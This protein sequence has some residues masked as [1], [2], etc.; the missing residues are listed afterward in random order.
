MSH[1]FTARPSA[2][3]LVLAAYLFAATVPLAWSS[4]AADADDM[5]MKGMS[6]TNMPTHN[7]PMKTAA[8]P[9]YQWSGCYVG[10]NGGGGAAASNFTTT[11]GPGGHLVPGDA[12][13]VANDGTGSANTTNF[14]GGGQAGCNWQSGTIVAGL[15]GDFDFFH[16]A[17]SFFNNTNGLPSTGNPFVIGHSLTT[18][19]LATVRPRIGIAAGRNLAYVAGGVAFTK[20]NYSES[21]ADTQAPPGTGVATGS[22]FLTGWTAGAGWEYAWTDRWTIRFEYL[23]AAFPKTSAAGAIT[24][25]DGTNP[26]SGSG[27][28]VI[29]VARA[30]VNLKF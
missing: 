3:Q 26:L 2:H 30:A 19:Y 22:K 12:A 21:Y 8:A 17:S 23:L 11:V 1:P 7:M 24:G 29:Q 28:L 27:N 18:N 9:V 15:E 20:V 4:T 14:I 6:M 13:T 10:L 25:A 5:S 16:S